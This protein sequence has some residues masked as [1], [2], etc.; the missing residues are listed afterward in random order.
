MSVAAARLDHA[1]A[2]LL[3]ARARDDDRRA[4]ALAASCPP[5]CRARCCAQARRASRWASSGC[6][7]GSTAS[8]CCTASRSTT[9]ASPTATASCESRAYRAARERGEIVYGEFATDPCRS[10]FKRVQTLFAPGATITDN[11][12][13]NVARL[14]ERFIAMTETP[15]PVQFDAH[16][17]DAAGVRPYEAPGQLT[18]AHPHLD[19][20]SGGMLNYAA[21]LGPRSSYRFFALDPRDGRAPARDRLAARAASRPTCTPSGSPSAGSCSPSSRSSSTRCA[22][23]LSGR[24]YIENYRWKPERG[25]RFT[26]DRPHDRRAAR[27]PL[28]DRRRASPST[29]STPSSA[30]AR[31]SSTCAPTRTRRSSRTS[32]ST[33]CARASR[34]HAR[35]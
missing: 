5:G 9:A 28:P 10:L 33:A 32:T 23:A 19:R 12:N 35:R 14:G 3:N 18:T 30:T 20:A 2:R 29:T 34:S 13:V 4:R 11:A 21:K 6:A 7:T 31:S 1:D 17:L 15:M 25:T 27:E 26:L 8:R 24:P 16:T 22:L